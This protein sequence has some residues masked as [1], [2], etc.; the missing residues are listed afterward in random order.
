MKHARNTHS[1]QQSLVLVPIHLLISRATSKSPIPLGPSTLFGESAEEN[2][3][4]RWC[5]KIRRKS[6]KEFE[7]I[8]IILLGIVFVISSSFTGLWFFVRIPQEMW[9]FFGLITIFGT[10]LGGV[11]F[12]LLLNMYL[13]TYLPGG[14]KVLKKKT[15]E[16]N[17][18]EY[19]RSRGIALLVQGSLGLMG[20]IAL[21]FS[22]LLEP[23]WVPLL[24]VGSIALLGMIVLGLLHIVR[25][26]QSSCISKVRVGSGSSGSSS[27]ASVTSPSYRSDNE[28][29][30]G[31][32]WVKTREFHKRVYSGS[33]PY[34]RRRYP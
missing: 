1:K 11:L 5:S 9:G 8:A 13:D 33:S 32:A 24:Y 12:F 28:R 31:D 30:E 3:K 17:W 10:F 15:V 7:K 25:H 20:L 6:R 26:G 2:K 21:W 23:S 16:E 4:P 19:N 18:Y 14:F 29:K 27:V 34:R 22:R